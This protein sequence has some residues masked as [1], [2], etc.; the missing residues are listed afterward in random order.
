MGIVIMAVA[1]R[2]AVGLRNWR[3]VGTAATAI[4]LITVGICLGCSAP[5]VPSAPK[6]L[7]EE[8]TAII[9]LSAVT[10][11]SQNNE[12]FHEVRHVRWLPSAVLDEF[13]E[14]ADPRQPFNTTDAVDPGLPMRQLIVAAV[15]EKY[16]IVSY[17]EGGMFFIPLQTRIFELTAG[18][19]KREWV[20]VGGG[21]NFRDLK[22]TVESGRILRFE[23]VAP[24][25]EQQ[26][27]RAE[28]TKLSHLRDQLD[29]RDKTLEN[30]CR[31]PDGSV[32]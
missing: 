17:S 4:L 26:Q 9:N 14:I 2:V 6:N 5:E 31:K 16:C 24:Y 23:P 1:Y 7:T 8:G 27:L 15:S 30:A 11:S 28:E 18:R 19:V 20:S 32:R 10:N 13:G 3:R 21:L 12:V 25:A 22:A 29:R